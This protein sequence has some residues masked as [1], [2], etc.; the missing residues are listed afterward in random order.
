MLQ[1]RTR[2][3]DLGDVAIAKTF[4]PGKGKLDE[5]L[6]VLAAGAETFETYFGNFT[7]TAYVLE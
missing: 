7:A 5:V 4:A 2:L 1:I 3:S 6:V